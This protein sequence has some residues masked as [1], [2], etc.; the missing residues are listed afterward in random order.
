MIFALILA[1][2]LETVS[3]IPWENGPE[4]LS[5]I[6][7]AGKDRYLAVSDRGGRAFVLEMAMDPADGELAPPEVV[8]EF[9]LKG[10]GKGDVEGC[11]LDPQAKTRLWVSDENDTSVR[12]F[13]AVDG[14]AL[15][16]MKLDKVFAGVRRN[17]SL[18]SLSISPDGL[19]MWTANEDTLSGD[20]EV[21]SRKCGGKVRLQR[22]VRSAASPEWKRDRQLEYSTDTVGGEDYSGASRNGVAD[23]LALGGGKVLVLEREFS[24]KNPLFPDFRL[25]IYAIG[26]DGKKLVWEKNGSFANYEGMT[27]GPKLADGTRTVVMVSDGAGDALKMIMCL[28]VRENKEKVK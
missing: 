24:R 11:A 18:E 9:A 4:G 26:S 23:V 22:F 7:W 5:G 25:R 19:E 15:S 17:R 8:R 10:L 27:F 13:S 16:V 6:T 21:A 2:T 14:E 1:F 20:G 3:E 12:S 28:A